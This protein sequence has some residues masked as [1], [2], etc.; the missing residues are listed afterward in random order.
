MH[1]FLR[2]RIIGGRVFPEGVKW[3]QYIIDV[4]GLMCSCVF[5]CFW[6]GIKIPSL[7]APIISYELFGGREYTN[8]LL[9]N[10]STID[11]M[12]GVDA[13]QPPLAS[14]SLTP[15]LHSPLPNKTRNENRSIFK[16]Q[17]YSLSND[18]PTR[19]NLWLE[20]IPWSIDPL[21]S[22]RQLLCYLHIQT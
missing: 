11:H 5:L 18:R 14:I 17:L 1:W 2:H 4:L 21:S 22:W 8:I 7:S 10:S 15:F 13:I 6:S 9:R 12:N 3:S 16:P 19:I 20:S